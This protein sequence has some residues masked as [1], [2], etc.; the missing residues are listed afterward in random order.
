MT[1]MDSASKNAGK[2]LKLCLVYQEAFPVETQPTEFLRCQDLSRRMKTRASENKFSS[3]GD[4]LQSIVVLDFKRQT[5][6]QAPFS[7][8]K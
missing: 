4:N 3:T 8:N 5:R 2:Q 7:F 6:I 1:A